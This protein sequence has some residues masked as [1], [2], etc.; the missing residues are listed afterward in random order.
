M[1][2]ALIK[3]EARPRG[4]LLPKRGTLFTSSLQSI[5][6][7]CVA[8]AV[9]NFSLFLLPS[10]TALTAAILLGSRLT[11]ALQSTPQELAYCLTYLSIQTGC[12]LLFYVVT[13]CT[14]AREI[15]SQL[16]K[17]GLVPTAAVCFYFTFDR[18]RMLWMD[19]V[20][21]VGLGPLS[22][23]HLRLRVLGG[24]DAAEPDEPE[25]SSS[26]SKRD[27]KTSTRLNDAMQAEKVDEFGNPELT[28]QAQKRKRAHKSTKSTAAQ[29][30][31]PEDLDFSGDDSGRSSDSDVEEVVGNQEL[32]DSLPT[33]TIPERS[34][35]RS[36][37][38]PPKKRAKEK[39]KAIEI[40]IPSSIWKMAVTDS[41]AEIQTIRPLQTVRPLANLPN[42]C[43]E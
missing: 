28:T 38:K 8:W 34:R 31:D 7:H 20:G 12:L 30:S 14:R 22:H 33:K 13:N 11:T 37:P 21:S 4:K 1:S 26:R 10:A 5:T 36:A 9:V 41:A 17:L 39:A 3:Y 43:Q 15:Y 24:A 18:R 40:E 29:N 42:K 19:T 27:R 16:S 2:E 23:L 35:Q 25:A 32:A 6:F